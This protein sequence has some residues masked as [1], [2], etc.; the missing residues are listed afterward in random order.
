MVNNARLTAKYDSSS[1]S[2]K[3]AKKHNLRAT[4]G[5]FQLSR[6]VLEYLRLWY[7]ELALSFLCL[8][9]ELQ[10]LRPKASHSVKSPNLQRRSPLSEKVSAPTDF[11][12]QYSDRAFFSNRRL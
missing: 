4:V 9:I 10:R 5:N 1:N 2:W 11:S 8:D 12:I 7:Y 6:V 3:S